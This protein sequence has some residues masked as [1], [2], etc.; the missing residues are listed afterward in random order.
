ME[1]VRCPTGIM[2]TA[3]D[4]K[5]RTEWLDEGMDV[6]EREMSSVTGRSVRV[7]VEAARLWS[8][9]SHL[10]LTQPAHGETSNDTP[11]H[12]ARSGVTGSR[13]GSILGY[14][15]YANRWSVFQEVTGRSAPQKSSP[16][17][18]HGK[19]YENCSIA[20]FEQQTGK[21]VMPFDFFK[22]ANCA[23]DA[24]YSPDG[25][26]TDLEM[27]ESKAP[28]SLFTGSRKMRPGFIPFHYLLGQIQYGMWLLSTCVEPAIQQCYYMEHRPAPGYSFLELEELA[29]TKVSRDDG[30]ASTHVWQLE[31]F[32]Q[33]IVK[34]K[35]TKSS[36]AGV[37][38]D[39]YAGSSAS[40]A[41]YQHNR[42]R[43]S[44]LNDTIDSFN[45]NEYPPTL[46]SLEM[47]D[48]SRQLPSQT[49]PPAASGRKRKNGDQ[50]ADD[51]D[52]L[53]GICFDKFSIAS[54]MSPMS[55]ITQNPSEQPPRR[56]DH[57]NHSNITW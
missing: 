35:S 18:E 23:F 44:T 12:R 20:L 6:F 8:H 5:L 46:R 37:V 15:P 26:T 10:R 28:Y 13:A 7:C 11:W 29:V 14:S 54:Q 32:A 50:S 56:N 9:P 4:R 39:H 21:V 17:M 34:Y 24:A 31:E 38:P 16:P 42:R 3:I 22:P 2:S 43:Q 33:E 19:F 55:Q 51:D 47:D 25:F 45:A 1:T 36:G 40:Y 52:D 49:A 41:V 30:W 48:R 53:A 27:I 57:S